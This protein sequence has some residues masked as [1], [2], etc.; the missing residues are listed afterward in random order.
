MNCSNKSCKCVC[1]K[2]LTGPGTT[3][4]TTSYLTSLETQTKNQKSKCTSSDEEGSFAYCRQQ[5]REISNFVSTCA[6]LSPS[7]SPAPAP[8]PV[9]APP[10][11]APPAPSPAPSP[12][13][14]SPAPA[15]APASPAPAPAPAP[16]SPAPSP[17]PAP[18]TPAPAPTPAPAAAPLRS[19][20]NFLT[21]RSLPLVMN[22]SVAPRLS[23]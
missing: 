13:A 21:V 17:V 18:A 3:C 20:M 8:A 7:P 23:S 15:P 12:P 16:A 10:A 2:S 6:I 14:P 1:Q 19:P 11:P 4:T 22:V 9:P 5:E